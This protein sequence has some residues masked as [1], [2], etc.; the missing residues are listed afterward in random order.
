M[1][2]VQDNLLRMHHA[3]AAGIRTVT[4]V[5]RQTLN[6]ARSA[7]VCAQNNP[8]AAVQLVVS[9][10]SAHRRVGSKLTRTRRAAAAVD[11]AVR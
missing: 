6:T 3:T 7:M 11:A 5:Q 4:N 1:H 2:G 9:I 10:A 8:T